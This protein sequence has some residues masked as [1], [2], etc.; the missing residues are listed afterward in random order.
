MPKDLKKDFS[1]SVFSI[2]GITITENNND[3]VTLEYHLEKY[4]TNY[5]G[6]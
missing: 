6:I 2:R 1:D 4:V 3:S 5:F